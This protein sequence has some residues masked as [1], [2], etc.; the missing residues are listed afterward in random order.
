MRR[1]CRECGAE[2]LARR[3][4]AYFC[5]RRC[6]MLFYRRA[7][8]KA[9]PEPKRPPP[10]PRFRFCRWCGMPF[11]PKL[12]DAQ[13]CS[14]NCN[15][16]S[17]RVRNLEHDRETK[18]LRY[19][20]DLARRREKARR[21]ARKSYERSAEKWRQRHRAWRAANPDKAKHSYTEHRRRQAR[22]RYEAE[23]HRL[24]SIL[25]EKLEM[26]AIIE[27][28]NNLIAELRTLS[29][30]ELKQ[31]LVDRLGL[32]AESLLRTACLVAVLE[33]R[34]ED[35]SGLKIGLLGHLRKIA[36]GKL[37]P[38]IV[39][40]FAGNG[41]L[42]NR[43]SELAIT[44]Q[45]RILAGADPKEVLRLEAPSAP[46]FAPAGHAEKSA[47]RQG[48]ED[49]VLVQRPEAVVPAGSP[50]DVAEYLFGLVV[51]H[52]QPAAV[53]GHLRDLFA[54]WEAGGRRRRIVLEDIA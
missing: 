27:A 37:L 17:W 32:T 30:D 11:I 29:T 19:A 25:A 31:Q 23:F 21:D 49:E 13:S 48:Q 9:H 36:T 4:N 12:S 39:V 52:D 26:A 50:R 42:I 16:A 22:E 20:A 38:E 14:S 43:I 10:C 18:R 1:A 51:K 45:R 6:G 15:L 3:K 54:E 35:L 28:K 47:A 53:M 24:Q 34:G 5:C 44:D 41:K 33:E 8:R 40:Q 46:R 7:Y 2:F